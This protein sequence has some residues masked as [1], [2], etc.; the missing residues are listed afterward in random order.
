MGEIGLSEAVSAVRDELDQIRREGAREGIRF[1][2]DAVDIEFEVAVSRKGG[3]E[4]KVKIWVVEA[5]TSA[6]IENTTTHRV[7]VTL[8]P[9]TVDGRL[10][11]GDRL[12]RP[13]R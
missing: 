12:A 6:S 10:E 3:T 1:G 8:T 4:G 7:S 5:G 11:V 13:S 9:H 2:V